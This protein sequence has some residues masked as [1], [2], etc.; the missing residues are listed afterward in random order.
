MRMVIDVHCHFTSPPA[1]MDTYRAGQIARG[2]HGPG[3]S[4]AS[5][6]DEAIADALGKRQLPAMDAKGISQA[7]FSPAAYSMGHHFGSEAVVRNWTTASNDL[8]QRACALFP[9][10]LIPS[11]QL[12]QSPGVPPERWLDELEFR[13][14]SQGFVGC[15]INPDISGG[16]APLTPS[17]ADEWWYPLYAKLEE[18]QVP[19]HFHASATQNPAF[20][21]NGVNYT[22][23]DHACAFD[24]MWAADRI[25][26]DFPRLKLV[27]TH[28]GGAFLLQYNRMRA[29]FDKAGKDYDSVL[30]RVHWDMAVYEQETMQT[31]VKLVGVDSLVYSCEMCGTADVVD[32]RTGRKFDDTLPLVKALG[33]TAAEESKILVDN[34]KA[35]FSRAFSSESSRTDGVTV[36]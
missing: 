28:G 15:N 7:I 2:P 20:H 32:K 25:F 31:M 27:I 24:I 14:N 26:R 29:L 30:R 12:P 13:V 33:L 22:A 11:C 1:A 8:I 17:V 36:A 19:A 23:W 18:L 9:G 3:F 4:A 6:G 34:A 35:L 21:F 5:L 10:R 16:V